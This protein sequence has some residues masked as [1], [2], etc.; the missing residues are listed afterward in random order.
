ML[1]AVCSV[2]MVTAA[3]GVVAAGDRAAGVH[4]VGD[5]SVVAVGAALADSIDSISTG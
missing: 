5:L 4:E 3:D 2:A 1:Q